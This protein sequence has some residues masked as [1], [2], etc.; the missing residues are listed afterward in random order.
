MPVL[1]YSCEAW[2]LTGELKKRL[3]TFVC[4]SLRKIF[5]IKWQDKKS[6]QEV[7]EM[8]GMSC[9][10]CQIRL[11]QLRSFGHVMRFPP[12][13]PAHKILCAGEPKGWRRPRGRPSKRWLEQLEENL[14]NVRVTGLASARTYAKR[15]AG[16]WKRKVDAAKRLPDACPHT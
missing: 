2:T 12:T 15:S 11:R 3:N 13:D 8:A 7:L 5:G 9:V 6:N 10:T 4:S 1:L 16:E 14:V